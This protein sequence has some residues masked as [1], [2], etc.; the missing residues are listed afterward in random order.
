MIVNGSHY[1]FFFFTRMLSKTS[2]LLIVIVVSCLYISSL[3]LFHCFSHLHH[4]QPSHHMAPSPRPRTDTAA[5]TSDFEQACLEWQHQV[6]VQLTNS[7]LLPDSIQQYLSTITSPHIADVGTGSGIWLKDLASHLPTSSV[8][9]G[10]DIDPSKFPP[11][12]SIPRNVTLHFGNI[13]KPFPNDLK[14]TFD[15]VH[16]RFLVFSLKASEWAIAARNL[17]TLLK[18]EGYLLWEEAGYPSWITIPPS[19]AWYELLDCAMNYA[20]AHRL[21]VTYV[22]LFTTVP[23]FPNPRHTLCSEC[24]HPL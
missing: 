10:L 6:M 8:L 21:D 1:T 2:I 22:L 7:A 5:L 20:G 3:S 15:L 13:L 14:G 12:R 11:P 24:F 19:R 17:K 16:V 18:P 4:L 9:T 23:R